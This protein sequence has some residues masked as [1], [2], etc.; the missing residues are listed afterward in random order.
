MAEAQIHFFNSLIFYPQTLASNVAILPSYTKV[1]E[2]QTKAGF[3]H[4]KSCK[5][6]GNPPPMPP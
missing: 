5:S 4:E 3:H 1:H 6:K 2:G